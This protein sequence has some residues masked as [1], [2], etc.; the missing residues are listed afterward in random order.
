MAADVDD[1]VGLFCELVV[2][3]VV[4]VLVSSAAL[5]EIGDVVLVIMTD[6]A[7]GL[8]DDTLTPVADELLCI[9]EA[10]D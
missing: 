4:A 8:L 7:C 1:D 5:N 10:F 2:V 6:E 9:G 3:V